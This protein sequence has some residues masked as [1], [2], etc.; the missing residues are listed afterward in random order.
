MSIPDDL[1][2]RRPTSQMSIAE[3]QE[4]M[5]RAQADQAAKDAAAAAG[6]ADPPAASDDDD[7][8]VT[9]ATVITGLSE[10]GS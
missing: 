1:D 5:A 2:D 9:A 10:A 3:I 6:S 4:L 7:D 8:D